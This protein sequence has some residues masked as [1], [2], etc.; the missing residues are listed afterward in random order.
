LEGTKRGGDLKVM[1]DALS[2]L[3]LGKR[4]IA[5]ICHDMN[6]RSRSIMDRATQTKL[7]L[8][9]KW[10]YSG[11]PCGASDAAHKAVNGQKFD[12]ATGML[13]DGKRMWPGKEPGCR[14]VSNAVISD[15][16]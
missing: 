9:A 4:R 5:E 2:T 10:L 7:G 11:A 12:P 14:C 16:D 3:P 8:Q 1:A 15:F 13:I 6:R